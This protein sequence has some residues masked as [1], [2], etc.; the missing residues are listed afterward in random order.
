MGPRL[1]CRC[2]VSD[3]LGH[4]HHRPGLYLRLLCQSGLCSTADYSTSAPRRHYDSYMH[5]DVHDDHARRLSE[6]ADRYQVLGNTTS[7]SSATTTATTSTGE[8]SATAAA[9]GHRPTG[10]QFGMTCPTT[11]SVQNG[12][13]VTT[14]SYA[15]S[16]AIG[17]ATATS[18][19]SASDVTTVGTATT[20]TTASTACYAANADGDTAAAAAIAPTPTTGTD[21]GGLSCSATV[22]PTTSGNTTTTTTYSCTWADSGRTSSGTACAK[23]AL[24]GPTAG[25]AA[26]TQAAPAPRIPASRAASRRLDLRPRRP[27]PTRPPG[28]SPTTLSCSYAGTRAAALPTRHLRDGPDQYR[29]NQTATPASA[30][31]RPA[32]AMPWSRPKRPRPG[33]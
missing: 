18:C 4:R 2:R 21:H 8:T 25:T 11:S 5:R 24:S 1:S 15:C 33:W 9:V 17:A 12:N 29:V 26:V 7:T 22:G 10:S 16:Y 20:T 27:A 13:V 32:R 19:G 3:H 31:R 6:Q 30:P 14:T 28:C 23:S